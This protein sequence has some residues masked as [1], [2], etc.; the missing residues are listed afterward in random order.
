MENKCS[1]HR[2]VI[3]TKQITFIVNDE[4][5]LSFMVSRFK[6]RRILLESLS[7]KLLA[8]LLS[9]GVHKTQPN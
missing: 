8:V 9:Y 3:G 6:K 1:M 5:E 7:R 4:P 2:S